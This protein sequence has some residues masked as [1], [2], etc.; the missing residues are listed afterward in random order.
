MMRVAAEP[1]RGGINEVHMAR[2]EFGKGRL[3]AAAGEFG[4][5]LVVVQ[6]GHLPMMSAH[7]Q[8]GQTILIFPSGRG[9]PEPEIIHGFF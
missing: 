2:D 6:F 3:G 7:R 4:E 8:T 9:L 5:Q 1:Q